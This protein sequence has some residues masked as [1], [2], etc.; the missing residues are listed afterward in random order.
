MAGLSIS[1]DNTPREE[2]TYNCPENSKV[3]PFVQEFALKKERKMINSFPWKFSNYGC[4]AWK[5]RSLVEWCMKTRVINRYEIAENEPVTPLAS[6]PTIINRCCA[7]LGWSTLHHSSKLY[8]LLKK[9]FERTKKKNT[10]TFPQRA[11]FQKTFIELLYATN[12]FLN[13]LVPNRRLLNSKGWW[14][15][16]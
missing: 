13:S 5:C 3:G 12:M 11:I 14:C 15:E 7:Q 16:Q 4:H 9:H 8:R 6:A 2:Y 10:F 1:M